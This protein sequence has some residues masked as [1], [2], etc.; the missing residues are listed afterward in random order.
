[1]K[2]NYLLKDDLI[3]LLGKWTTTEEG[4]QCLGELE[5]VGH[6]AEGGKLLT[7][8]ICQHMGADAPAGL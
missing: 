8:V 6:V 3:C 7:S 5:M 2:A 4:I 1:M